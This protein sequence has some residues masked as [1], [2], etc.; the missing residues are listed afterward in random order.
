MKLTT[1]LVCLIASLF[2]F[3]GASCPKAQPRTTEARMFD[4]CKSTYAAARAAY[5]ATV[6]LHLTGQL[7]RENRLKADAAWLDFNGSFLI[8]FEALNL[9]WKT[10]TPEQLQQLSLNFMEFLRRL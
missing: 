4:T 3:T 8:T 1:I 9:D 10:A 7:S 2:I 6:K 5:K